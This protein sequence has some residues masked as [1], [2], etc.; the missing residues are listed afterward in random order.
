M[1]STTSDNL[2]WTEFD[3]EFEANPS[4]M[5][6]SRHFRFGGRFE[7]SFWARHFNNKLF[8]K[9]GALVSIHEEDMEVK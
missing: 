8:N 7:G 5:N 6:S 2:F 4:E 1:P 3:T 9:E